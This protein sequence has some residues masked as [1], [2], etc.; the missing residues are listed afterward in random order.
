MLNPGQ[1]G[2]LLPSQELENKDELRELIS[3]MREILDQRRTLEE[4]NPDGFRDISRQ[5]M[6]NWTSKN[7]TPENDPYNIAAYLL[8]YVTDIEYFL[9]EP[10]TER[11]RKS[12]A[13]HDNVLRF[14]TNDE[15]QKEW[16]MA[17]DKGSTGPEFIKAL[18]EEKKILEGIITECLKYLDPK[19]LEDYLDGKLKQLRAYSEGKEPENIPGLPRPH[20]KPDEN[21]R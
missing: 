7:N 10:S 11:S 6:F 16:H 18:T 13:V 3:R 17:R 1:E 2:R 12:R 5:D 19:I 14:T 4:L 8:H 21:L 9:E 15:F 20:F